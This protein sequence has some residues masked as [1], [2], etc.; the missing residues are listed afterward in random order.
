MDID[1]QYVFQPSTPLLEI[2]LRG[3]VAYLGIL[4]LM[5]VIMGRQTGTV[6]I[7]D[8][9]VV[10]LVADAVQNGMSS[11]YH[12]ITD[13]M[14]L[15]LTILFWSFALDRLGYRIPMIEHL[16]HPAPLLLVNEGR[17][18]LRNMRA[19]HITEGELMSAIRHEGLETLA[20]VKRAYMEGDGTISVVRAD[21]KPTGST[22]VAGL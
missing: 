11:N 20:E 12:S 9:L 3:S 15:V 13:G 17:M 7:S 8:V 10:V 16:I 21:G 19:E 14:L 6:R 4:I 22:R 18:M 2:F 1:W 5:R